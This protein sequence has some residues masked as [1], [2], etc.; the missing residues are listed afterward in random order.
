MDKITNDHV[1]AWLRQ[2]LRVR[3]L[4]LAKLADLGTLPTRLLHRV[5]DPANRD[6]PSLTIRQ[7]LALAAALG[8]NPAE[9]IKD[10]HLLSDEG[11]AHLNYCATHSEAPLS[12]LW[13]NAKDLPE[14]DRDVLL[15]YVLHQR[16]RRWQAG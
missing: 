12:D 10:A 1:I 16:Q 5:F 4:S 3:D 2:Q 14:D 6:V 8:C 7:T 11:Y 13:Q 9:L 15:E